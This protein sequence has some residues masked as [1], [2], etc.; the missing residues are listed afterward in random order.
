MTNRSGHRLRAAA[1]AWLAATKSARPERVDRLIHTTR[2]TWRASR[3][4]I[5][6]SMRAPKLLV[7][8]L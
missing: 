4:R 7:G 3:A 1:R 5:I 8:L 6:E 2:S